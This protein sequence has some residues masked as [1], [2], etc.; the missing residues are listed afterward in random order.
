[1]TTHTHEF[2]E[3][4]FDGV[5]G[6]L[7]YTI[8]GD[9]TADASGEQY[10]NSDIYACPDFD[11]DAIFRDNSVCYICHVATH[12]NDCECIY[13][14]KPEIIPSPYKITCNGLDVECDGECLVCIP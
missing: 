13:T 11:Y 9:S 4:T 14:S 2:Y 12:M 8:T 10:V 6:A 5:Q 3:C 1:M 7:I